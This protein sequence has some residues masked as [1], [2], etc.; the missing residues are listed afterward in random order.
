MTLPN[1]ASELESE[2][3]HGIRRLAAEEGI[4]RMEARIAGLSSELLVARENLRTARAGDPNAVNSKAVAAHQRAG[5]P[6]MTNK[7]D[8]AYFSAFIV[9]LQA[10]LREARQRLAD[11]QAMRAN[12]N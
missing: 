3:A 4:R 10:H 12:R 11:Y 8:A 2:L 5:F 6:P 1:Y 9:M 7:Q